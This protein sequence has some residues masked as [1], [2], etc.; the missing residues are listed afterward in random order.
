VYLL[1]ATRKHMRH[2]ASQFQL[3]CLQLRH[4]VEELFAFMQCAFGAVRTTPRAAHA[5]P[6]P[7]LCCFLAYAL[8]KSLIA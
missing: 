7:L 6:I 2:V 5:V 4:R 3:A 1:T 8:Y